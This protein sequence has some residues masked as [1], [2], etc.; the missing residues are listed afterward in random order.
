MRAYVQVGRKL[1]AITGSTKIPAALKT[2]VGKDDLQLINA[3]TEELTQL[4]CAF[5]T[6]RVQNFVVVQAAG[7]EQILASC[8]SA[9]NNKVCLAVFTLQ[10]STAYD[11]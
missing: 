3:H 10:F 11:S 6:N 9:S 4:I 7:P 5:G 1:W 8:S 2:A